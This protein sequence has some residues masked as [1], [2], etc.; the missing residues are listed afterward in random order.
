MDLLDPVNRRREVL[1]DNST[2]R[3]TMHLNPRGVDARDAAKP[4]H[5]GWAR[6]C[7]RSDSRI[8]QQI[9]RH[10]VQSVL[11]RACARVSG[12]VRASP[13]SPQKP[14]PS[15]AAAGTRS[16][17]AP[18]AP[19]VE[20][21]TPEVSP[22]R[23]EARVM[24]SVRARCRSPRRGSPLPSAPPWPD[25]CRRRLADRPAVAGCI[26]H[27]LPQG[28]VAEDDE[29]RLAERLGLSRTPCTER[30]VQ[31]LLIGVQRRVVRLPAGFALPGPLDRVRVRPAF[32][33]SASRI[34]RP[35]SGSPSAA[36]RPSCVRL[37]RR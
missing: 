16:L 19:F 11:P 18:S 14:L 34:C 28:A 23:V 24:C 33:A 13:L 5:R 3:V 27:D 29:G 8:A 21:R 26:Q 1:G 10:L 20:A 31:R 37:A 12:R 2:D 30:G 22:A 4:L 15:A 32:T 6:Q 17:S 25:R 36:S 35:A 7:D 9:E